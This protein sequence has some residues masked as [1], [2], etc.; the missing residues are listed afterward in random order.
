ML[1]F[2]GLRDRGVNGEEYAEEDEK[3]S[4]VAPNRETDGRL[5]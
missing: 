1:P 3:A 2:H 5:A 4:G